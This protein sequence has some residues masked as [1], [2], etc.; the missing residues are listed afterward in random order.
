[1]DGRRK[2]RDIN[3]AII[4]EKPGVVSIPTEVGHTLVDRDSWK[5]LVEPRLRWSEARVDLA[6]IEALAARRDAGGPKPGSPADK[7][8]GFWAGSLFGTI[9]DMLGV[10]NAAYLTVDDPELFREIVDRIGSLALS[11]VDATLSAAASRGLR[12]D[13][14]HY[15]ED[16]CYKNGPLVSPSLFRELV[17]PWYRKATARMAQDGASLVSLDCDGMIDSLLPVWLENGVNVMFPIE[18]GTWDASLAPWRASYGTAVRGVGGMNKTV[19]S[20]DRDAIDAEL[21]RLA[22]LVKLGGYLPCPDHRIAP[23]AEWDLVRYYCDGA[24]KAFGPGT[25]RI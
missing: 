5:E 22:A 18:V 8:I 13:F 24:R 2:V 1:P 17:G 15:W 4:L 21:D 14:A 19:F 3:G 11:L 23:D 7:P 25:S 9:R 6:G 16:I 20:R 10:E 12:F